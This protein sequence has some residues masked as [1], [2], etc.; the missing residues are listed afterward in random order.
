MKHFSW[1]E[2]NWPDPP[3]PDRWGVAGGDLAV[4]TP[5]SLR[6]TPIK[7]LPVPVRGHSVSVRRL[8]PQIDDSII[9]CVLSFSLR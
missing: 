2:G 5:A 8:N 4:P 1:L 7:P 6:K 9:H 3:L